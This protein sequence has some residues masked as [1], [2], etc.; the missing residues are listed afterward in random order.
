MHRAGID[1]RI[2]ILT[3]PNQVFYLYQLGFTVL[4]HS[5]ILNQGP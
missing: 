4:P 1:Y 3:K 5:Y 2:W